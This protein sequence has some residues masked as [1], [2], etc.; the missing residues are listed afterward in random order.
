V[1][2]TSVY[3]NTQGAADH[4]ACS[5]SYLE[6][7]RVSGGGPRFLKIGKAVRYKIEDL[8]AFAK[9][10]EHGTTA[11]YAHDAPAAETV[12]VAPVAS[13]WVPTM[14]LGG[15]GEGTGNGNR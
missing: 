9:G 14:P 13:R 12:S 8:D 1:A 4:L 2:A 10:C 11:E 3:T 6:K 5:V 15:R 7:R